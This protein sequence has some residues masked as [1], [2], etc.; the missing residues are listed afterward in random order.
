MEDK[1]N[2]VVLNDISQSKIDLKRSAGSPL[3][4]KAK[5]K[6]RESYHEVPSFNF[7]QLHQLLVPP[8]PLET[9]DMR[10]TNYIL[11]KQNEVQQKNIQF[12]EL[13]RQYSTA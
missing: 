1:E 4:T 2:S 10:L 11:V 6:S 13:E 7:E 9:I 12:L 3:A 8:T 5:K